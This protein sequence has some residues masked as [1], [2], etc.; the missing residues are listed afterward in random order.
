MRVVGISLYPVKSTRAVA[1]DRARVEWWG[2]AGDRRWAVVAPDGEPITARRCR[3]LFTVAASTTP[4]GGLLLTAPGAPSLAVPPPEPAHTVPVRFW[5][6]D[7]AAAGGDAA[8]AWLTTTLGRPARLVW[9]ADTTARA[10]PTEVGGEPGDVFHLG[11]TAPLH[12]VSLG[13]LRKLDDWIAETAVERGEELPE[14]LDPGRFRANVVVEGAVAF[15]EDGWKRLRLGPVD[16]RVA[17]PC[18]RCVMTTIDPESRT[19]GKEPI[20]TLARH[21]RWD[22]WAWFGIQLVPE[23]LGEIAVG[24]PV[25]PLP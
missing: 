16:F 11:D 4:D 17:G 12:L 8:D 5:N 25:E 24:D 20:R 1:V 9:L 22:G 2:L 6:L 21:R 18:G 10:V 15:A 19:S 3:A 23:T 7:R 13:S 14:P